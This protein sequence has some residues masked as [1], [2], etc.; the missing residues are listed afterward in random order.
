MLPT[1]GFG[2]AG[3]R[4][5][6][7]TNLYYA[8]ARYY[9]PTLGRFLEP[10]P[11]GQ[12]GGINI[13][14]Y[15]G[16][17]PLNRVDPYGTDTIQIGLAGTIVF[18]IPFFPVVSVNVLGGFGVAI[19]T[20]GN[21]AGYG[22]YGGG[23]GS[24]AVAGIGANLQASNADTIASL[25]GPFAAAGGHGGAGL[26]GSVEAFTGTGDN[27]Q[28]VSGAS[29]TGGLQVGAAVTGGITNTVLTPSFNVGNVL[30][31]IT[32]TGPS[33][34]STPQSSMSSASPAPSYSAIA[35][36]TQSSSGPSK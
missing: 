29:I 17:D 25:A 33:S 11:I 20:H 1:S 9:S 27:N 28:P 5:D 14:A 35:P 23:G 3:Y 24:G 36:S 26:G 31:S 21:V 7:E 30:S 6:P 12:D 19:D 18:P 34:G 13:Y 15:V 2:Y 10:D 22:Y 32:G 8:N 4:Y 16:N